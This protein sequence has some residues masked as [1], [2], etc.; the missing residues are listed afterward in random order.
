M[1]SVNDIESCTNQTEIGLPINKLRP[2]NMEPAH[3]WKIMAK[4][5]KGV[6]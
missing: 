4:N 1:K 3:I 5:K 6:A 2:K